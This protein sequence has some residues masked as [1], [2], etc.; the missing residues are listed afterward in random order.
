MFY[1]VKVKALLCKGA[2]QLLLLTLSQ[3]AWGE[4]NHLFVISGIW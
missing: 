4:P 1:P 3:L 2:N